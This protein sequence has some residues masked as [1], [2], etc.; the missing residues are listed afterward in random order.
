MKG[1]RMGLVVRMA[2]K[3]KQ[4]RSVESTVR[5]F[6]FFRRES[7]TSRLARHAWHGRA[8]VGE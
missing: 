1:Y 8:T 2:R 3:K 5:M 4:T 6:A 7:E